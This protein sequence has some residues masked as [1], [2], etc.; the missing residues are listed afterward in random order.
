MSVWSW[1]HYVR[2]P[3][4]P[5]RAPAFQE[6]CPCKLGTLQAANATCT[7]SLRLTVL[8]L[9]HTPNAAGT[10]S[11]SVYDIDPAGN[12]LCTYSD[13]EKETLRS[14]SVPRHFLTDT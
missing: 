14:V 3:S 8:A 4:L 10:M 7:R 6:P 2:P 12:V 9:Q 5:C 11:K 13:S 1:A